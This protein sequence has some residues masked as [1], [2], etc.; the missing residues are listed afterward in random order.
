MELCVDG[1]VR[2]NLFKNE[3]MFLIS[4][5]QSRS[6]FNYFTNF[7]CSSLSHLVLAQAINFLV[8]PHGQQ[9]LEEPFS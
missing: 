2:R 3:I 7:A 6:A 4:F 9:F 5:F 1:L 8:Y